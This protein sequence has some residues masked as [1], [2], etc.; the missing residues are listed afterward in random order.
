MRD[1]CPLSPEIWTLLRRSKNLPA[2][3]S[4][5]QNNGSTKIEGELRLVQALLCHSKRPPA[6]AA[7]KQKRFD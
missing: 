3:A 2:F 6:F 1:T 4:L 7:L 5:K